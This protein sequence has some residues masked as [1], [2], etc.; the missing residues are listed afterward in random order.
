MDGPKYGGNRWKLLIW[1]LQRCVVGH[2][3]VQSFE[4]APVTWDKLSV[5][6]PSKSDARETARESYHHEPAQ[7][8]I[9]GVGYL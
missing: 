3:G 1:E 7:V 9:N 4:C 5:E 8:S 6:E 2:H